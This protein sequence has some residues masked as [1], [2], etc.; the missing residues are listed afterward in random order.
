MSD[1]SETSSPIELPDLVSEPEQ[2]GLA[3]HRT[4]LTGAIVI[5]IIVCAAIY[6]PFSSI[7]TRQARLVD[8][9][10][11][12]LQLLSS[13]RAEV[14]ATWLEGTARLTDRIAGSELLRLF[15]TEMDLAAGNLTEV[16]PPGGL[17]ND[18]ST[19]EEPSPGEYLD[20]PSL[21]QQIP[22][23]E[24][25]LT[26]F[27]R[28]A[29]FFSGQLIGRSDSAIYA[30]SAGAPAMIASQVDLARAVMG[31][32]R[33]RFGPARD[34]TQGL[35]IDLFAPIAPAQ[36]PE[37][38][39]RPVAALLF[40]LPAASDLRELLAR[41]PRAR[42]GERT[43]LIQRSGR[44][45]EQLEPT[46]NPA[47]RTLDPVE[48]ADLD[49][50]IPFALRS[51]LATG[52]PVYSAGSKVV[53]SS[54]WVVQE[55]DQAE[56]EAPLAELT[57]TVFIGAALVVGVVITA[58]GA[59]WWR[60][61]NEHNKARA[62]QFRKLAWRIETQKQLLDSING[63]IAD[64]IGLKSPDGTYR[65]VN[66]AFADT[67]GRPLAQVVGM[68]DAALFGAGTAARLKLSDDLAI[69]EGRPVTVD[70]QIY[71]H[72]R[73]RHFQISKVP[74]PSRDSEGIA[75]SG[76]VSVT[77]DVTEVVEQ[78]EKR[79]RAVT[80]MV[81]ALVRA[82]ELRDPYLG[83]HSRRVAGL[84]GEVAR[85]CGANGEVQA[86]V[87]IAANLSQI[88]KLA[89]PRELLTKPDRLNAEEIALMET[90]VEH[91]ETV[92]RDVDFDLPV[93]DTI[94]QMHERLDGTGYPKGL[95]GDEISLAA[96]IL[97]VCDVF[98]ARVE[99]RS[100]RAGIP[101]EHALEILAEIPDRYDGRIV[102]ALAEAVRS[103][104]GEKLLCGCSDV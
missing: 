86:T 93:V 46:V 49:G 83:G 10:H 89:I 70:E 7:Q 34:S 55:L 65:Y 15:A 40:T 33:L 23:M 26:D 63:T 51:G 25:V 3:A 38:S 66:P 18:P 50:P 17:V 6:L 42:P 43:V 21:D 80:Q 11:N 60:L 75:V 44:R 54:F 68:D 88:G 99:P 73:K 97:S 27:V 95:A 102:S 36:G 13:S 14:I 35:V 104:V 74:F 2:A 61:A 47:I 30:G 78:R 84:A 85:L 98:C 87:E 96:R 72:S 39:D 76:L 69:S 79:E 48:L 90:H 28:G 57:R 59:F 41:S 37:S 8:D 22:Y 12:E 91:A 77:R 56:A 16:P 58:F 19:P 62:T 71:I 4:L 92:L 67:V 103:V 94:V 9:L 29:G 53:G 1:L 5:A 45:L 81:A 32:G 82:V 64:G 20:E 24:Q 31:D 52:D 101:T 100:Y